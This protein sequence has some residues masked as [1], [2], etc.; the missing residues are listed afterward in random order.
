MRL[1]CRCLDLIPKIKYDFKRIEGGEKMKGK[2]G[3]TLIELMIVIFVIAIVLA[4]LTPAVYNWKHPVKVT[5]KPIP[6]SM[7]KLD[8]KLRPGTKIRLELTD[9][10]S[11][12]VYLS[13]AKNLTNKTIPKTGVVTYRVLD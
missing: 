2:K 8:V 12:K 13:A 6:M 1:N 11:L 5:D 10:T 3:F 9:G 7:K 4:I